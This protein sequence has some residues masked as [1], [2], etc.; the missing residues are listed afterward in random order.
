MP[1]LTKTLLSLL[2]LISAFA[3][4]AN[5]TTQFVVIA[6]NTN[7]NKI[8]AGKA[9]MS[10]QTLS[11]V[12]GESVTLISQNGQVLNLQGPFSGTINKNL[13]K[14][15]TKENQKA[16][17]K[18]WPSTLTKITKLVTKD[19][20]R[21]AVI[22][23]SRMVVPDSNDQP[24]MKDD[25]WFMNVDSSGNRCVRTKDVFMWRDNPSQAI[26]IDLRSQEAKRT[27]L[28]WEKNK[29]HMPL[30]PEFIRDG[31]LIVMKMDK[32][33][34]RFNLHVLPVWIKEKQL[35]NVLLWMV[36]RNCTRQS[37]RLIN[38]LQAANQ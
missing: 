34:R 38:T 19:S 21:T 31:I 12:A 18:D 32:Q 15:E 4:P 22:G 24:D 26:K 20:N 7:N 6:S 23:A 27:G 37:Q 25:F 9:F 5:A 14:Q 10:D 3:L 29:Y 16:N 30:P 1:P 28:M 8:P 17:Q 11:L 35:G 13:T 33:P 36:N 2:L